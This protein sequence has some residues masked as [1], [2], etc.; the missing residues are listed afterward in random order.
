L[1]I[2]LSYF[3]IVLISHEIVLSCYN[4]FNKIYHDEETFLILPTAFG[5]GF[6]SDGYG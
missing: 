3:T 1:K 4:L 2:K 6:R 5:M